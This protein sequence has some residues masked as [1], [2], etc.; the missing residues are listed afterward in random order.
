ME[1]PV[2]ALYYGKYIYYLKSNSE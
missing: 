2:F 1:K